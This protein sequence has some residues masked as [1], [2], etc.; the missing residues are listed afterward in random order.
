MGRVADLATELFDYLGATAGQA[1]WQVTAAGASGRGSVSQ[2]QLRSQVWRGMAWDH[3]M[4]VARPGSPAVDDVAILVVGGDPAPEDAQFALQLA[5]QAGLP[6]AVLS[7][8]PVQPLLGLREDALIAHT[9]ARYLAEGDPDWPL[10][11]P[12]TRAASA[13]MDAAAG[14]AADLWGVNLRGFV[15]TGASK[16]AWTT[17]LAAAAAPDRVLGIVPMAFDILDILP[18]IAHQVEVWGEPSPMIHDYL[19]RGLIEAFAHT[20]RGARLGWFVDP[21]SYRCAYTMPKLV[22]RGANDPYWP[23]DALRVSGRASP[24]PSGPSWCPTAATP[25]GDDPR[26]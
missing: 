11:F 2:L 26:R 4:S 7:N 10:L 21:Y 5:R 24:T 16:L 8:V 12:M 22:V 25:W 19:E 23:V 6:V 9:F 14:A 17:Y 15:V 1:A 13:A 3:R 20:P 18:Q